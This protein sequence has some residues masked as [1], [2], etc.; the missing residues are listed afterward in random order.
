MIRIT[1]KLCQL[2]IPF[3][4]LYLIDIGTGTCNGP[5]ACANFEKDDTPHIIA[6]N[7]C[8]GDQV[9]ADNVGNISMSTW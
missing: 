5:D 4:F 9:C 6:D 2:T 7:S 3:A 1:V 8:I